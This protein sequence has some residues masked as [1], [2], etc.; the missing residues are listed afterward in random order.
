[1]DPTNYLSMSGG[2]FRVIHQALPVTADKPT[3][4]EALTSAARCSAR[5]FVADGMTV[6]DG[7][8]GSWRD[9]QEVLAL[10]D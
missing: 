10:E 1:M 9:L 5:C 8:T 2:K 4:S 7:D 3:A 6:W